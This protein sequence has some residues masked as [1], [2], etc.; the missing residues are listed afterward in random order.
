MSKHL[1]AK[2]RSNQVRALRQIARP[3]PKPKAERVPLEPLELLTD[4]QI[5]ANEEQTAKNVRTFKTVFWAGIVWRVVKWALLIYLLAVGG[6]AV[7]LIAFLLV[8]LVGT[9]RGER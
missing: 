3:L 6:L 8:F 5:K 1:R 9:L 7:F 2:A 4:E